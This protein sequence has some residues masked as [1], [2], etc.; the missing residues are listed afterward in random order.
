LK[1]YGDMA[2]K[3]GVEPGKCPPSGAACPIDL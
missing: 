1:M 2:R 3:A